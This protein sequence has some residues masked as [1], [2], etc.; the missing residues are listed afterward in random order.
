MFSGEGMH[1]GRSAERLTEVFFF[2][3]LNK[4]VGLRVGGVAAPP[5]QGGCSQFAICGAL[6]WVH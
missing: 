5:R 2:V 3:C 4:E 1:G 6:Q